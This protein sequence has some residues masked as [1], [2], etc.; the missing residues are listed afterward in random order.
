MKNAEGTLIP[1]FI[2]RPIGRIALALTGLGR[3]AT[4]DLMDSLPLQGGP[5][6]MGGAI[7]GAVTLDYG[8][9]KGDFLD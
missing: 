5:G 4:I 2:H 1:F 9:S 3:H 8:S 6:T 7:E